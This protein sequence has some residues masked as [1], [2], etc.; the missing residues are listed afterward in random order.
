MP[1]MLANKDATARTMLRALAHTSN[2]LDAAIS[3]DLD[4]TSEDRTFFQGEK[5]LVDAAF[6][7][8]ETADRAL[9]LHE[10]RE[11]QRLQARVEVGDVIL[12]RGVRRAKKRMG[13]EANLEAAN[14]VFGED[15]TE[16]VDAERHMEPTLV[17]M[18]VDRLAQAADF[19]GKAAMIVDLTTRQQQQAQNFAQ[20]TAADVTGAA[21]DAALETAIGEG[22]DTLY[23]LEKRLLERFPR[24]KIYVRAFFLDTGRKRTKKEGD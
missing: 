15:I 17:A 16:I 1:F 2:A 14:Q 20:R 18:S 4:R 6:Q 5:A 24:E 7:K 13:L 9:N 19:A 12:D 21:L 22:A 3:L 8:V 10:L 11:E 23:K